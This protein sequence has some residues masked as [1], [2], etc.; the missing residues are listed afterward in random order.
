MIKLI[1]ISLLILLNASCS[2]FRTNGEP[3]LPQTT[4]DPTPIKKEEPSKKAIGRYDIDLDQELSY[5]DEVSQVNQL[6]KMSIDT[7]NKTSQQQLMDSLFANKNRAPKDIKSSYLKIVREKKRA[8]RKKLSNKRGIFFN[9]QKLR[10]N[11]YSA[12]SKAKKEAF[13]KNKSGTADRK[14][15]YKNLDLERKH[16]FAT[17]RDEKKLFDSNIKA[18]EKEIDARFKD[19]D[20]EF[21]DNLKIYK[22]TYN[23]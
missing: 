17:E 1:C 22:A 21:E 13:R 9:D 14:A 20:K 11:K 12:Q 3:N 15:F 18:L 7:N 6:N 23:K 10:R 5:K 8:L 4:I 16:F 2:T 19:L